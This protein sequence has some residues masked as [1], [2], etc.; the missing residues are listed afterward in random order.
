MEGDP[1]QRPTHEPKPARPVPPPTTVYQTNPFPTSNPNNPNRLIASATNPFPA[2]RRRSY[3]RPCPRLS[4]RKSR[5]IRL[6]FR[7]AFEIK[8]NNSFVISMALAVHY[9]S[10][11]EKSL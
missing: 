7:H 6:R 3:T 9:S 8:I 10:P 1:V 5:Q 2:L 11:K 4:C